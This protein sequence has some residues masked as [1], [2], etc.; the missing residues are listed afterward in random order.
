MFGKKKD[1]K[2][3]NASDQSKIKEN[4]GNISENGLRNIGM[5][6]APNI[7]PPKP[8]P[9]LPPPP[10]GAP[11][12]PMPA[13]RQARPPASSDDL[14]VPTTQK[15]QRHQA[16]PAGEHGSPPLFIKID[17]YRELVQNLSELKSYSLS[18]RDALDALADIEKEIS[19]GISVTQMALD[20][21]NHVISTLDAKLLRVGSESEADIVEM[22]K[23][24]DNYVKNL[25]D[26][27]ERIKH[28]LRTLKE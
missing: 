19:N 25:Y 2:D 4:I 22:P 13:Q 10:K 14:G 24:M 12:P 8:A 20:K 28:E 1:S 5:E 26:N 27:M 15:P 6:T 18:L 11:L 21:I 16:M 7:P 17:K 23:E 9:P 3:S